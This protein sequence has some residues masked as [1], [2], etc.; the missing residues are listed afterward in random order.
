MTDEKI[1]Q[2]Q[3]IGLIIS[4]IFVIILYLLYLIFG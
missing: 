2:A 3:K 1:E 4:A